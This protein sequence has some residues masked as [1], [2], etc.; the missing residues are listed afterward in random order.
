MIRTT[1]GLLNIASRSPSDTAL[2]TKA[3]CVG[4]SAAIT[5][6]A[7]VATKSSLR[8]NGGSLGDHGWKFHD[9]GVLLKEFPTKVNDK[10]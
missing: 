6:K 5:K 3:R 2:T 8:I 9:V 1:A 10:G 4:S 7:P